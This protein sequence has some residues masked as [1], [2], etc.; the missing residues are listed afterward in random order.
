MVMSEAFQPNTSQQTEL[1]LMSSAA[2]FPAKTSAMP[3]TEKGFTASAAAYGQSTPELLAKYDPNT[4]SWR[5]SQLCL[6][7]DYQLFSETWPRSGLMRNG[8]AYQLPPLV[9]LTDEIGSGLWRTPDA[10]VVSGGAANAEDRKRQGHAIGLHDQVNTPSMWPTPQARAQTDTPSERRRNTPCLESQVK[11]WATPAARDWRSGWGRSDN[12][13]TP[14]LPEQV[15]GQLNPTWVE[16]L[17]GFPLG[18][19]V[20]E[21]WATRLS[22]K[23]RKLSG[24][25]SSPPSEGV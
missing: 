12:G 9:R 17:M 8:T 10:S 20:L 13:H 25:Q 16:W 4:S 1:P 24:E 23:S 5:T 21:R 3:G 14:Q 11:M 15:G 7:E 18:W 2:G 6:D 19:T 22:R